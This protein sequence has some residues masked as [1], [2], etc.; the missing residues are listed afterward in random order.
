MC[1]GRFLTASVALAFVLAEAVPAVAG[2]FFGPVYGAA[3]YRE[4]PQR[5]R[6]GR[7][8]CLPWCCAEAPAPVLATPEPVPAPAPTPEALPVP[9]MSGPRTK[10]SGVS[11]GF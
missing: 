8:G 7:R 5:T 10:R 3:Y 1:K 6:A 9:Q 2:S 4:Y 11:G